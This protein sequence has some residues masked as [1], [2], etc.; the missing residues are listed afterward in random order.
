MKGLSKGYLR[1]RKDNMEKARGRVKIEGEFER[2]LYDYLVKRNMHRTAE[3]F[4][5]EA[6]LQ[7][8]PAASSSDAVDVPEGFLL[9]WW[10]LNNDFDFFRQMHDTHGLQGMQGCNNAFQDVGCSM[11]VEGMYQLP[12]N[13][14]PVQALNIG[15]N[16]MP[17]H[18]TGELPLFSLPSALQQ[19]NGEQSQFLLPFSHQD[20]CDEL[21]QLP[22]S[23]HAPMPTPAERT[24][25]VSNV[26]GPEAK[27]EYTGSIEETDPIIENLLNSFWLFEQDQPNLFEKST[28]GE[29]SR[30]VENLQEC[31]GNTGVN[32]IAGSRSALEDDD[33]RSNTS[34]CSSDYQIT[35]TDAD[36][37]TV[38]VN[39]VYCT[40]FL[41][42][43]NY[44]KFGLQ[45]I[46]WNPMKKHK[47][48]SS[49]MECDML[50][51]IMNYL[52]LFNYEDQL[53]LITLRINQAFVFTAALGDP[54]KHG[55][56]ATLNRNASQEAG[57][58]MNEE[59]KSQLF[60]DF[61][62]G[63]DSG[64]FALATLTVLCA[65]VNIAS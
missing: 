48:V 54:S 58:S 14:T 5:N 1:I 8:N 29:S 43:S 13:F 47:S 21:Q 50:S 42:R 63:F 22:S 17:S 62:P 10:S 53:R 12:H 56:E 28:V 61:T 18:V 59:A 52:L 2:Y 57:C 41:F 35:I 24:I 33:N 36:A 6:N 37:S 4:R 55:L 51:A 31:D 19:V 23:H 16:L 49:S 44:G 45:A 38:R 26:K 27:S 32:A 3:V 65:D 64:T 15:S 7:L 60:D 11:N 40:L 30:N 46:S 39:F 20:V 25:E 34:D 9:E